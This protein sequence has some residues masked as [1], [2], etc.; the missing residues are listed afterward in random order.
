MTD[1][2]LGYPGIYYWITTLRSG[3]HEYGDLNGLR[4]NNSGWL[5]IFLNYMTK[6][7]R[8]STLVLESS[9]LKNSY[10]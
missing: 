3:R 4:S 1:S 7:I 10:N 8:F 9:I 5:H 6:F 2:S